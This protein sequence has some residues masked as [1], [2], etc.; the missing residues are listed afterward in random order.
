MRTQI[1][2]YNDREV[3]L[4]YDEWDGERV[5]RSFTRPE[6][7]GRITEWIGDVTYSVAP[8]LLMV[9]EAQSSPAGWVLGRPTDV[10][11]CGKYVELVDI[12]RDQYRA[13]RRRHGR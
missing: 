1:K 9:P 5:V 11:Y 10:L 13:A 4:A 8:E 6:S 3:T 12:I 2:A 7:G